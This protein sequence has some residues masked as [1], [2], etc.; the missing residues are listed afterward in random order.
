MGTSEPITFALIVLARI[1]DVS[2][3]T[4]RT[5]AIVQGRRAF[6]AVLGFVEA[7]VYVF[8]VAKVLLNIQDHPVYVLAY[9]LGFAAGTYLGMTVERHLAFGEQLV[10]LFTL[11]GGRLVKALVGAGYRLADV[12][13]DT[14]AG[15]LT[16]VY[17]EMPRREVRQLLHE[18][19]AVDPSCYCIVN[20]VRV[21]QYLDGGA[22]AGG[23]H[24]HDHGTVARRR[25]PGCE[26]H[27]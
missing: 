21:A 24:E 11:E 5:A 27:P 20:D 9:G 10:A 14:N 8:A 19:K 26:Q 4:L 1:A 7:V 16:I 17:V 13:G 6:A 25:S 18:A 22:R 12:H 2:L 23:R 3:D 15:Q